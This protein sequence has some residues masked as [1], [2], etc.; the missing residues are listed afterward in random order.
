MS[1]KFRRS[2]QS[3]LYH[4]LNDLVLVDLD[5]FYVT[6]DQYFQSGL[7]KML[8]V[9]LKLPFGQILYVNGRGPD[10]VVMLAMDGLR[11]PNGIAMSKDNRYHAI[12]NPRCMNMRGGLQ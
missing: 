12:I 4:D 2:F 8:E 10:E 3:P 7:V 9:N 5:E 11:Y 6:V 1:L